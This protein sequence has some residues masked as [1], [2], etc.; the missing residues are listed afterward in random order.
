MSYKKGKGGKKGLK[1]AKAHSCYGT[2]V[3]AMAGSANNK[4]KGKT[5]PKKK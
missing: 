3:P 4:N 5:A 1:G 2:G